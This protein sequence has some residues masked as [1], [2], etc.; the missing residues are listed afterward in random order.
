MEA[1]RMP[2]SHSALLPT[3]AVHL[4]TVS[5]VS[6]T[7]FF[8]FVFVLTAKTKQSLRHTSWTVELTPEGQ[9]C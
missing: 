7:V 1:Y 4:T 9:P 6:I 2:G 8:V 5:N 3:G